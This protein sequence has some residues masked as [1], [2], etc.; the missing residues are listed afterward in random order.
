MIQGT[1]ALHV[2]API[3]SKVQVSMCGDENGETETLDALH[4]GIVWVD[5]LTLGDLPQ[6]QTAHSPHTLGFKEEKV[7]GVDHVKP[8]GS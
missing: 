7:E 8:E 4:W 1:D 5:D 3:P 2:F 6:T